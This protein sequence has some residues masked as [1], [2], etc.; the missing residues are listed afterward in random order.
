MTK[1]R[2]RIEQIGHEFFVDYWINGGWKNDTVWPTKDEALR[3]V[4]ELR[5]TK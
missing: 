4:E 2:T 3:R 5:G 1:L